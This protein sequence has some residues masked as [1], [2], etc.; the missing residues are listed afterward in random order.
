MAASKT[1]STGKHRILIVD[2]HPVFRHG[3]AQLI[4]QENDLFVCGEAE[5]YQS[6]LKAVNDLKPDMIIVDITLKDT[7]GIDLIKE[8][9]KIRR[10]L[11][12]LVISMHDESLYAERALRAGARGYIM[13]QEASESVVRAIREVRQG[14]IYT[15]KKMTDQIFSR[16]IE[17]NKKLAESPL[18]SLTDREIEVFQL[19]G[20][21]LS[22][23][24]IGTRLHL[25]VKTIG[26][27]RER[28]KEKLNLKTSTELLRYAINWVENE[29]LSDTSS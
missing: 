11:A 23:S 25:S 1:T 20:E 21:G 8:I 22:I 16:F 17:G 12:M 7:S 2:D 13:K 18:H 24:E 10:D 5:D 15:S 6:A 26:T 28:I 3:L 14:S 19:I 27:Y 4:N 9:H 29:K